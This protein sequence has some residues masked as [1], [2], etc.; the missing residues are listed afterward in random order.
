MRRSKPYTKLEAVG[1]RRAESDSIYSFQAKK[2]GGLAP[3]ALLHIVRFDLVELVAA[4]QEEATANYVV[5]LREG[6]SLFLG[7]ANEG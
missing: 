7:I 2:S 3:A 1:L 4:A 6:I 5:Q